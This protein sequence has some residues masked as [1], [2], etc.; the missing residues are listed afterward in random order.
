MVHL[1]GPG[2]FGLDRRSIQR[3]SERRANALLRVVPS[4][5]ALRCAAARPPTSR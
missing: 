3:D 2:Q 1:H 5:L 4:R